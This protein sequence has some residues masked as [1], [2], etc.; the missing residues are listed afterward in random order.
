M[1]DWMAAIERRR[2]VRRYRDAPV[3]EDTLAALRKAVA[4]VEPLDARTNAQVALVPF[5]SLHSRSAVGALAV[6]SPAPW[7]FIGRAEPHPGR[8]E[9]VG[10]RMEQAVLAATALGLGTCW[11][12]G[13]FRARYLAE[14]IGG[15]PEDVV[16]L[17]PVGWPA[18]GRRQAWTRSLVRNVSARRGTRKPLEEFAF[19]QRWGEPVAPTLV[20]PEIWRA[21]EMARLAPS[22]SNVQPWYFLMSENTIFA[23]AD[24]RPQRWNDR[25]GRPYYRLDVGIAMCHFWLTLQQLGYRSRWQSLVLEETEAHGALDVPGYAVPIARLVL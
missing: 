22:W 1:T 4:G 23:L 10:F 5:S 14:R 2:S 24:S 6:A 18:P 19:W 16:A 20:P 11:M 7:Y 17:S 3:P 21:L 9:E 13:F 8:M 15:S 25:P 12:A